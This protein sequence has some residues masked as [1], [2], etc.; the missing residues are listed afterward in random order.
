MSLDAELFTSRS[1][2]QILVNLCRMNKLLPFD[3]DENIIQFALLV[4][5]LTKY[6]PIIYA[7]SSQF[8]KTSAQSKPI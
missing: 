8:M 2:I 3:S 7:L 1:L 6:I 5:L 4:K